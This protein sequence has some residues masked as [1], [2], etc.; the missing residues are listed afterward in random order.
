MNPDDTNAVRAP[1]TK[2]A[3]AWAGAGIA[4]GASAADVAPSRIASALDAIGVQSWA[5]VASMAATV[6]TVV[7]IG[8][9]AWRRV[10]RPYLERKGKMRRKSRRASD[11]TFYP[12]QPRP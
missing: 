11:E 6:Y 2:I 10:I 8:E 7:L 9:I 12:Q 1:V 5:D 3:S 4:Q